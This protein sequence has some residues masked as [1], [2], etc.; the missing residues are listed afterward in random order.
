MFNSNKLHRRHS[1]VNSY[2]GK[3]PFDS[4][5]FLRFQVHE[6][7][8]SESHKLSTPFLFRNEI[9]VELNANPASSCPVRYSWQISSTRKLPA[10][11]RSFS[12]YKY[13]I[14]NPCIIRVAR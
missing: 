8:C 13:V 12:K 7:A 2:N 11:P 6:P 4:R 14:P 10:R 5:Y 3:Q 9:A 1:A